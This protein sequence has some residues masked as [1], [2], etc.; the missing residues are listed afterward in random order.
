MEQESWVSAFVSLWAITLF[1]VDVKEVAEHKQ[2]LELSVGGMHRLTLSLRVCLAFVVVSVTL[3][4]LPHPFG[5]LEQR[6][7]G[8]L[9]RPVASSASSLQKE[10]KSVTRAEL[11]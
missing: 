6:W 1:T 10:G 3:H 7:W 2:E 4:T 9:A 5:A 8:G 11:T